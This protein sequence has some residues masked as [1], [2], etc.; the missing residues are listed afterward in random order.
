[1]KTV[2]TSQ[3]PSK[4]LGNPQAPSDYTLRTTGLEYLNIQKAEKL[5]KTTRI[6]PRGSRSQ[7]RGTPT[8]QRRDNFS[9]KNK[10]NGLKH[11][12]FFIH[13]FFMNH[14][15]LSLSLNGYLLRTLLIS[16]LMEPTT[17]DP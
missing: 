4:G 14:I 13:E 11:Q 10:C 15:P 1:M 12:Y 9:V 3:T 5:S 7:H 16:W 2:L 8:G 6:I 17:V